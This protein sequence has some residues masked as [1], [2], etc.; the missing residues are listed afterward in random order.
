MLQVPVQL[1]VKMFT[2][3]AMLPI[4]NLVLGDY[5][6]INLGA[7]GNYVAGEEVSENG[8]VAGGFF[9]AADVEGAFTFN[10]ATSYLSG[11]PG[12]TGTYAN[13]INNSGIAVGYA[14]NASGQ[15]RAVLWSSP[16]SVTELGTLGGTQSNARGIDNLGRVVGD[17]R[18]SSDQ[19]RPFLWTSS[20]GMVELAMSLGGMTAS[21]RAIN[22]NGQIAGNAR[23]TS[24]ET[25][26]VRFDLTTA[27][28]LNLGTLGGESSFAN[29]ISPNGYVAGLSDAP[30]D[31]FRPF[32]WSE[33][34]GMIDIFADSH[35]GSPFGAAYDV[36]SSGWVVG[37]GE[38]ND[39][40]DSH[41]FL[42]SQSFGL[43]DLNSF[44][45]AGSDW[46]LMGA[47]G[48][49]DR[50]QITGWGTYQGQPS[51]FLLSPVPE[52][53]SAFLLISAAAVSGLARVSKRRRV[54]P[55]LESIG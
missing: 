27:T 13:S 9:D 52:P 19:T 8:L 40:F 37:Y 5:V 18:N 32:F 28:T 25:R 35:L 2:F 7:S 38:I 1:F 17:S 3:I 15:R 24:G 43:I 51:G 36:N 29:G 23:L 26:A 54:V 45:P 6:I 11:L 42:W 46:V 20:T 10:G 12:G 49:N 31:E 22:D 4:A 41:A 47:A 16:S 48:I 53:S 39:N 55:A 50:G 44:L 34:T 33:L 14:N 30:D 21:A